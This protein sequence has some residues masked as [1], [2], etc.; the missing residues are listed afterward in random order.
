MRRSDFRFA[1]MIRTMLTVAVVFVAFATSV[2]VIGNG[3]ATPA[4]ASA[5]GASLGLIEKKSN[6]MGFVLMV[7]LQR[8]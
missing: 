2:H 3:L 1:D 4:I 5:D 8:G 7:S 6:R